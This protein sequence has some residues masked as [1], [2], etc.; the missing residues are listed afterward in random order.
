MDI[1]TIKGKAR[2]P[3]GRS[4][5]ARLRREG[6]VPAVVYGHGEAPQTI[7]VA[8][9]EIE[10]ALHNMRHVVDVDIDGKKESL[11]IKEVQYDHLQVEPLHLDL[12]RVDMSERVEVAVALEF[13][14]APQGVTDGGTLVHNVTEVTVACPMS[15]I[16]DRITV[17]IADVQL[18]QSLYGRDI[19]APEGLE[20]VYPDEL[21][22]TVQIPRGESTA[23]EGEEGAE[24]EGEA[25]PEVISRGKAEEDEGA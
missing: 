12:M 10:L 7:A 18:G 22:L 9:R 2:E 19:A 23:E 17:N 8:R 13:K 3:G 6:F 15:Q 21:I 20:I 11:L 25:E 24:G 1:E 16:P 14:G 4:A 5:N